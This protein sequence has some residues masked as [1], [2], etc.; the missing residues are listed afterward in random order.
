MLAAAAEAEAGAG[1]VQCVV[2]CPDGS[3]CVRRLRADD[4]VALLFALVEA[5]YAEPEGGA[6]L[7]AAFSLAAQ[8]PRRVLLRPEGDTAGPS[9]AEAGLSSPQESLVVELPHD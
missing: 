2:R 7:P 9:L 6:P 4:G 8:F 5:E 3:R 1:R